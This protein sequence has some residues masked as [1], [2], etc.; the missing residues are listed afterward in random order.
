MGKPLPM[1]LRESVAACVQRDRSGGPILGWVFIRRKGCCKPRAARR[2][3]SRKPNQ[4]E[5][6]SS[7]EF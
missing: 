6:V 3:T 2:G 5:R 7:H 4:R 1:A